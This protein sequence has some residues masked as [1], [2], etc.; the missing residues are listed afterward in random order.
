MQKLKKLNPAGF[1]HTVVMA[2]VVVL[3]GIIGSYLLVISHADSCTPV[4]GSVSGVSVSAPTSGTTCKS[5]AIP[6]SSPV[7]LPVI[8]SQQVYRYIN[9][10]NDR[11]LSF[12]SITPSSGYKRE[13]I[14][15]RA[16]ANKATGTQPV[17]MLYLSSQGHYY[18]LNTSEITVLEK[19]YGWQD[20]GI[21]FFAY[22]TQVAKTQ[23]VYHLQNNT[24]NPP[25]I[26]LDTSSASE[27]STLVKQGWVNHGAIFYVPTN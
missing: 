6:A 23:P 1:S 12:N 17:H 7:S 24:I 11:L 16:Y 2:G 13:L 19:Q 4:S 27:V 5:T 15:F 3:V 26:H 9:S 22:P 21:A 10:A 20:K 8:P 25:H 18:T 14:A